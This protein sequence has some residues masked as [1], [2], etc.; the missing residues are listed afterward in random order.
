MSTTAPTA[1]L[2]P[3][4][5]TLFDTLGAQWWDEHGAM[6]MLHAMNPV[7]IG[8]IVDTL[9]ALHTDAADKTTQNAPPRT[10][11]PLSGLH[12][13]DVGCGGGILCEPLARLGATITGLDAASGAIA[14]AKAHAQAQNLAIAYCEGTVEDHAAK[15]LLYDGVLALEIIEHVANPKFFVEQVARCV[16]PGG[17]VIISTLNRTVKSWLLAIVGA[18]YVL[19]L[20]PRGTHAHDTFI[21]PDELHRFCAD[22]GLVQT[23]LKGMVYDPLGGRWLLANDTSV[24]YILAARKRA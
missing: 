5:T 8:F 3:H 14:T 11:S 23:R 13:L 18:E 10:A 22:A 20:L 16:R 15:G 2:D 7:R 19:S 9:A 24:N 17:F 12:L 6:A 21:T 4:S 1:T